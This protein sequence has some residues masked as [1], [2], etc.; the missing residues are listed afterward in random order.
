ML[1]AHFSRM[2]YNI[3]A[4]LILIFPFLLLIK[5]GVIAR[6]VQFILIAG[7]AEWIRAMLSYIT[8]RKETGE[9]WTRLAVILSAISLFTL[10]S[11]LIFQT[12]RIKNLFK[13]K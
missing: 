6:A 2:S 9:D 13:L 8:I 4:V 3:I 1:S 7:T 5:K 10:L 12:K 11:A